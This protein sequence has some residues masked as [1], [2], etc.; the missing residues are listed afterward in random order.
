MSAPTA[1]TGSTQAASDMICSNCGHHLAFHVDLR[2]NLRSCD[3]EGLTPYGLGE[4]PS[5]CGCSTFKR[6]A[7]ETGQ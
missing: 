4:M 6:P 3:Y 5:L 7:Q 1:V 2:G